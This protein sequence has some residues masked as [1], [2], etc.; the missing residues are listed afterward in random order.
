[1]GIT[2]EMFFFL[3]PAKPGVTLD[4]SPDIVR[5]VRNILYQLPRF[6]IESD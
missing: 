3:D 5:E 6:I 1:V 2:W 4:N